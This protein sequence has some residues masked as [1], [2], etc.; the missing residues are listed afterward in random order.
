MLH[1]ERSCLAVGEIFS[2]FATFLFVFIVQPILLTKPSFPTK[3][4]SYSYLKNEPNNH[5]NRSDTDEKISTPVVSPHLTTFTLLW[6]TGIVHAL[7]YLRLVEISVRMANSVPF[8]PLCFEKCHQPCCTETLS[9]R[10]KI[11]NF[12]PHSTFIISVSKRTAE[13]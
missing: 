3:C 4:K 12:Y 8:I 2:F 10:M 9:I 5:I 1:C 6:R 13:N 11:E 7:L